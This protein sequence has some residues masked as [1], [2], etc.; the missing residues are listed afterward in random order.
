LLGLAPVSILRLMET[1]FAAGANCA[2]KSKSPLL[3]NVVVAYED[4]TTANQA[5][6]VFAR[7]LQQ[8]RTQVEICHT[9]WKFSLLQNQK[10]KEMAA[11]DA[12][13]AEIVM[14]ATQEDRDLPEEVKSWIA[15]WLEQRGAQNA[16]LIVVSRR[17]NDQG[18]GLG[19]IRPYL[20][21]VAQRGKMEFIAASERWPD[22]HGDNY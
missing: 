11:R 4:F 20:R 9:M 17:L 12:A 19:S 6:K 14:I 3:F 22:A 18:E 13:A 10:L 5:R 8:A 16:V 2:I 7:W 21:E 15:L 1:T